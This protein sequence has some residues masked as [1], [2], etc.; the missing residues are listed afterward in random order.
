LSR[1][2]LPS[3]FEDGAMAGPGPQALGLLHV[4][5]FAALRER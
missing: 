5:P 1:P 4:E 2:I 3:S